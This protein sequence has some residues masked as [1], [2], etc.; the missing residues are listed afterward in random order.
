M[1]SRLIWPVILSGGAGS[2]LWPAS[3]A[4]YPK[5]FLPLQSEKS[6]FE[7]TL[8]RFIGRPDLGR[9]VVV[10]NNDHRFLVAETFQRLGIDDYVIILEPEGR[11]TAPAIALAAARIAEEDP[12]ATLL[13]M[14]SDHL[15]GDLDA[16]YAAVEL[17]AIAA[18]NGALVTFGIV[19]DRPET[20][21]GYIERGN[22]LP[23]VSGVF[24]V[25]NFIEKPEAKT[26]ESYLRA[27]N[28]LWNSGIFMLPLASL[29]EEFERFEP[30][31]LKSARQAI[32]ERQ[33]D[34]DFERPQKE[35]FLSSKAKSVDYAIME[36][37]ERAVVVPVSMGWNDV[38]S[39]SALWEMGPKDQAGNTTSGDVIV[40]DS[41]NNILRSDGPGI[42]AVGIEDMIVVTT[43]DMVLVAPKA[44]AQNIKKLVEKIKQEGRQE[45]LYHTVVHRPW[46]SFEG[47]D[48]GDNFQVKR[49]IV[50]P[51]RK[52][53]LQAH[54]HRAEHWIVV[55]GVARV[56]RDDQV[57][58]LRENES[59]YIPLGAKHRLENP[60]SEPLHIIE[61][62]SGTYL[63]EDD[64]IR[65]DDD[66]GRVDE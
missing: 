55:K 48:A 51:G 12:D 10:G 5:Q 24:Q 58:D 26:A 62:Q 35:A 30:D 37:T 53:S 21:F 23:G 50:K 46:G 19:P 57:F 27:G 9:P 52:L 38:G 39:W 47:T 3:R 60:G 40:V 41:S 63:G 54:R 34:L 42:A 36:K 22:E 1:T 2:R 17:G 29:F 45:H 25:A 11:N 13:V 61:V 49:L 28:Y 15:I 64:I 43:K 31:T 18:E 44:A 59:T 32:M 20:A 16:F 7:Q 4:A 56:T 66:F 65:F 33:S 14:P 8:R 6:L